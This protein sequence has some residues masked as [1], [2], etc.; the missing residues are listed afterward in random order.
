[1]LLDNVE[2]Y[3]ELLRQVLYDVPFHIGT[4]SLLILSQEHSLD[5]A[6]VVQA[7]E[8]WIRNEIYRNFTF[9]LSCMVAFTHASICSI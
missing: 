6:I 7:V 2:C 5:S 9:P 4:T 8:L 3:I 1:M